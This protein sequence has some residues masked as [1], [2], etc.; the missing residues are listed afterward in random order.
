MRS[1]I[2]A[3]AL[4]WL[5]WVSIPSTAICWLHILR[6][7][8]GELPP[9]A[10]ILAAVLFLAGLAAAMS[11]VLPSSS[12]WYIWLYRGIQVSVGLLLGLRGIL[13]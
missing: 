11:L 4:D 13:T 3:I 6:P 2:S 10:L 7:L 8:W 12:L 1:D 9:I 5:L